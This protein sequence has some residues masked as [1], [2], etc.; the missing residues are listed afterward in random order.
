M[1]WHAGSGSIDSS[2]KAT[3]VASSVCSVHPGAVVGPDSSKR[4]RQIMQ[5]SC[6]HA[7]AIAHASQAC[8][9]LLLLLLLLLL[10]VK[11]GQCRVG[12]QPGMIS[13]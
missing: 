7:G 10:Q 4:A 13:G 8:Q 12:S 11:L 9:T 1:Q 2:A 3:H 6:V 5:A